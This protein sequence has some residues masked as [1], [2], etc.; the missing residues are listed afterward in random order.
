MAH[1]AIQANAR[2]VPGASIREDGQ[3]H[4][5]ALIGRDTIAKNSELMSGRLFPACPGLARRPIL[6]A[7]GRFQANRC[8]VEDGRHSAP[9]SL[10]ETRAHH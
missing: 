3:T 8:R 7:L 5:G 10:C 1:A 4:R 9:F 6:L 2:F